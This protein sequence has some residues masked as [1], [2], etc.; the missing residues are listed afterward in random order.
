MVC[1]V[2]EIYGDRVLIKEF[3][4]LDSDLSH[5][6]SVLILTL[7]ASHENFVDASLLRGFVQLGRNDLIETD[8]CL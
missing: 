2:I 5:F 3:D 7:L 1:D 4:T 6:R 8:W